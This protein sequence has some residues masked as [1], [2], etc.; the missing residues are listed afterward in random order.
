MN[1]KARDACLREFREDNNVRVL[2][3]SLKA[4]GKWVVF[5]FSR[6]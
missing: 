5:T 3:M 4:G 1:V 6:N 2:L